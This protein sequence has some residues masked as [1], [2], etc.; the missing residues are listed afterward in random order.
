MLC[1]EKGIH[2]GVFLHLF[3]IPLSGSECHLVRSGDLLAFL[4]IPDPAPVGYIF[5]GSN[6]VRSFT[7]P[8]NS[9]TPIVGS[10]LTFDTLTVPYQFALAAAYDQGGKLLNQFIN[11]YTRPLTLEPHTACRKGNLEI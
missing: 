1:A 9:S 10:L 7:L 2:V 8:D 6:F 5:S 3:Q 4:N 11:M